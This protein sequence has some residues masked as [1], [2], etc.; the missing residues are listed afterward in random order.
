M[1]PLQATRRYPAGFAALLAVAALAWWWSAERMAGMSA[2][3]GADLGALGWFTGTWVVMMAAMMLPALG[4]ALSAHVST[5]RRL[6]PTRWLLFAGAYLATW[7]AAGLIAYAVFELGRDALGS[8]LAWRHGGHWLTAGVLA[9]AAVYE[10]LPA[11][12][13]CLGHCRG[14]GADPPAADSSP[15]ELGLRSGGWCI[16]CSGAL[17][18]ALFA[19][20]AMSLTWMAVI[21][22]L[23]TLEK[24]SPSARAA[25]VVTA[26]VLVSLAVVILIAPGELPGFVVPGAGGMHAMGAMR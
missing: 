2:S 8:E 3:P 9:A 23:V 11:K 20:G 10:L 12:A 21:A 25:R 5:R 24:T 15:V 13:V 26:A 16:G 14:Q 4:P 17:M 18:A 7:A 1:S 6:T 22:T 19:L